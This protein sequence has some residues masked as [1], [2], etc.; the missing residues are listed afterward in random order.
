[1]YFRIFTHLLEVNIPT[2]VVRHAIEIE[3]NLVELRFS[4]RIK[5]VSFEDSTLPLGPTAQFSVFLVLPWHFTCNSGRVAWSVSGG[6]QDEGKTVNSPQQLTVTMYF[7]VFT[8]LL[9]VNIPIILDRHAIEIETNLVELRFSL[10]IKL[11]SFE[12]G[13]LRL[14]PPAQFWVFLVLV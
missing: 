11:V 8:H 2:I 4:L 9:E 10:R 3:T 13:T 14:D 7:R 12:D 6:I 5:L 1:M